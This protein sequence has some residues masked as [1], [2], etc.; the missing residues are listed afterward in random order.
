MILWNLGVAR[1]DWRKRLGGETLEGIEQDNLVPNEWFAGQGYG[2]N[3][4][5]AVRTL[6]EGCIILLPGCKEKIGDGCSLSRRAV[7][8]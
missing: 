1:H 8:T 4:G 3:G 7:P 6:D 2:E 5:F